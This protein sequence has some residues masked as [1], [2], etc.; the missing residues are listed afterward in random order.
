MSVGA[1]EGGKGFSA[2]PRLCCL[3]VCWL[4][5]LFGWRLGGRVGAWQVARQ[6]VSVAFT[7]LLL[8]YMGSGGGERA[9]EL[10]RAGAQK[11]PVAAMVGRVGAALFTLAM[12]G[13]LAWAI[14]EES[15][16]AALIVA[17]RV[18]GVGFVLCAIVYLAMRAVARYRA[19]A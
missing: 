16:P 4:W 18:V 15:K 1:R 6:A 11:P 8:M 2:V 14:W 17:R 19:R 10:N 13:N 3:S 12:A 9:L 5:G 7:L